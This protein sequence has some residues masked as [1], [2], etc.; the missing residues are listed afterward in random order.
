MVLGIFQYDY[1]EATG[2]PSNRRLFALSPFEARSDRRMSGRFDGICV[3]AQGNVWA[4][5][6][7]ESAIVGWR[8]DGEVIC[9]V[10]VPMCTTPTICCFG[11][12]Q[13]R[14][15][16]RASSMSVVCRAG[17]STG[18]SPLDYGLR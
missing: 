17:H 7:G 11:G 3:D 8:P 6:L 12:R 5:E 10:R 18:G 9:A 4:A 1:D 2:L 13:N 14:P 16:Y 15:F